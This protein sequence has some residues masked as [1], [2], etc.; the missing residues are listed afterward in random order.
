[1][2]AQVAMVWRARM[3]RNLQYMVGADNCMHVVIFEVMLN[4]TGRHDA[5]T[6]RVQQ[7]L[8]QGAVGRRRCISQRQEPA[9][10]PR[11]GAVGALPAT[12]SFVFVLRALVLVCGA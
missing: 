10:R 1:M 3:A 6:E 8:L 7:P 9:E 4:A 2:H 11:N 5:A 12:L